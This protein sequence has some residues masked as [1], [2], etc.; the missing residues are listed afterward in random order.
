MRKTLNCPARQRSQC[1]IASALDFVGDKWSLLIIRDISLFGKHKNKDFQ[2][3]GEKIPTNI[4]ANRLTSLVKNGLV[5]KHLYQDKPPRYE[6]HLTDA[7]KGLLPVI[8]SMA[9]WADSY[10]DG[11]SIPEF[12]SRSLREQSIKNGVR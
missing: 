3:A 6:Y 10:I 1:P 4:L 9:V 5:E 12:D 7:G 11:V 8:Q 2:N